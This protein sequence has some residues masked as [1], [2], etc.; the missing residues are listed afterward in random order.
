M[1]EAIGAFF[2]G[3]GGA[4]TSLVVGILVV[5][6]LIVVVKSGYIRTPPDTMVVVSGL[7]KEPKF[8]AGRSVMKFPFLER[9]DELTLKVIDV[10][11]RTSEPV[12]T[13]DFQSVHV[14]ATV[15]AKIPSDD[16]E[17]MRAAAQN[18]LNMDTEQIAALIQPVLEGSIREIVGKMELQAMVSDRKAFSDKVKESA[19]PDL[20]ALGLE[21]KTF[22]V[23]NFTDQNGVIRA[24]GIE[25]ETRI[26]K[27]AAVS[28]AR[29]A[30]IVREETARAEQEANKAEVEAKTAIAER[31]NELRIKKASLKQESDMK[32]AEADVAYS[33]AEEQQ[34]KQLEQATVDAQIAR[35]EREVEL[36]RAQAVA[37]EERLRAEIAKKADAEKY[38]KQQEADAALYEEQRI[39][40]AAAF[41]AEKDAQARKASADAQ[42]YEQTKNAEAVRI[43]GESDASAIRAKGEAEAEATLKKAEAM[44]RYGR[45]AIAEMII[46]VL[47]QLAS[48]IAKPMESIG[49]VQIIGGDGSGVSSMSDN[50]P[51]M[52]AKVFESVKATTGI[53]L[54]DIARADGEHA[55]ITRDI[56]VKIETDGNGDAKVEDV[57]K[58]AVADAV[59][60]SADAGVSDGAAKDVCDGQLKLF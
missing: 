2:S 26:K 3:I 48:E 47:P 22:N 35:T 34:R 50:V 18:F 56:N 7:R 38:A 52:M 10:D 1:F 8:A 39:A 25:N 40:E 55:Q 33:I 5:V 45:A 6:L 16:P 53:D 37:E 60:E 9:K 59:A 24:L 29:N 44:Q 54:A 49:N 30:Q 23:Q 32:Q 15:N 58:S 4:V 17:M 36:K 27:D 14:N 21:I 42:L 19:D 41:K 12:P 20:K 13:Q 28:K 43:T 51:V 57:V 46:N 31:E 11:V